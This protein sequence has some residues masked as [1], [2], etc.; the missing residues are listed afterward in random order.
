M[1]E[2]RVVRIC[3]AQ[4]RGHFSPKRVTIGRVE[5]DLGKSMRV[6]VTSGRQF[7]DGPAYF[8]LYLGIDTLHRG[9]EGG[10]KAQRAT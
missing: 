4:R 1:I 10:G 7:A 9:G 2:R 8:D 5:E 3:I 6:S